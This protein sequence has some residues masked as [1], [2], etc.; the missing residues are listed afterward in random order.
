MGRRRTRLGLDTA[1]RAAAQ[2]LLRSSADARTAER[3]RFALLAA[4]GRH[5]LEELAVQVGRQ[6]STLQSWLAK[7]QT[8]GLIG[9]LER[10]T[11]PGLASPLGTGKIESQLQAGLKAGRWTSA[12]HVARWLRETHGITRSRKSLYYWFAKW[13]TPPPGGVGAGK[14]SA[15]R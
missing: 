13:G 1:E 5:T 2:R 12:A 4:T 6:R 7:Y 11:P 15:R 10:D 9:L 3:M 8:G 14:D